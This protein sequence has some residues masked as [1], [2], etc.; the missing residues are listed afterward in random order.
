MTRPDS[1][2]EAASYDLN[3]FIERRVTE[4]RAVQRDALDRRQEPSLQN[5]G[6]EALAAENLP[7]K[8]SS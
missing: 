2:F 5:F 7:A 4:R 6:Q 3:K 8:K 1:L